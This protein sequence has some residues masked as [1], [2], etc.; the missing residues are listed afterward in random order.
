MFCLFHPHRVIDEQKLFLVINISEQIIYSQ[1]IQP[2][3][4][5]NLIQPLIRII[6][7][8]L[9][10]YLKLFSYICSLK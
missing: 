6:C 7:A 3:S 8:K 2:R 9:N 4:I 1:I 10:V 5:M